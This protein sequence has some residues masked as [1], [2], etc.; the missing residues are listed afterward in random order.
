M[1]LMKQMDSGVIV[2]DESFERGPTPPPSWTHMRLKE[3]KDNE[4]V[5][6]VH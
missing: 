1:R 3:Q 4:Q 2:N 6:F 5:Y